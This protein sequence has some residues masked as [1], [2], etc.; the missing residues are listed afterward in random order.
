MLLARTLATVSIL[1]HH[2]FSTSA[3]AMS[4]ATSFFDLKAPTPK[5][6][7]EF[8][9][10]AGKVT[11]IVNVASQCGFTGQYQGLQALYEKYHSQGL[12]I[13]GFPSNEFGGQEPG[14]AEEIQD[15]CVKNHGVT[16]PLMEKSSVNGDVIP[17]D[18]WLHTSTL[19]FAAQA[20]NEVYSFLKSQKSGLLGLTRIKWNFEKFLIGRDGQ[21]FQRYGSITTPEKIAGDIEQLLAGSVGGKSEL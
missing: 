8:K 11:L 20:E 13:L 1:S 3:S 12:E 21:V 7:Y 10:L 2:T 6:T 14:S 9:Q 16:F 4:S 17:A 18:P 15:F 19:T 5:G